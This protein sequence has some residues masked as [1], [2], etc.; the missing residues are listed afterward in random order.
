MV[1]KTKGVSVIGSTKKD[2]H[3]LL[4]KYPQDYTPGRL[5]YLVF[6]GFA[7]EVLTGVERSHS[8]IDIIIPPQAPPLQG[9]NCYKLY[10]IMKS[11]HVNKE[12][13][14]SHH[15]VR[16]HWEGHNVYV[17]CASFQRSCK[18][19]FSRPKDRYD[20]KSLDDYIANSPLCR[21]SIGHISQ[22][23]PNFFWGGGT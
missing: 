18:I 19:N 8:D 6:G 11:F 23:F 16:V 15:I 14:D 20:L 10:D 17:P 2:L 5:L 13:A 4:R 9:I 3:A 1:V 7:T 21:D 12:N 22:Y